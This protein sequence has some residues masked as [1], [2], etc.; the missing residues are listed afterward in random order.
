MTFVRTI[1]N[2]MLMTDDPPMSAVD[3][4]IWAYECLR[5]VSSVWT[6][7]IDAEGAR[8]SVDVESMRNCIREEDLR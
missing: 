4:T 3:F 1:P 8:A 2:P 5:G 6:G 7:A